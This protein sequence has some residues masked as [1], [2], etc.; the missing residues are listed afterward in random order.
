MKF[1]FYITFVYFFIHLLTINI[2]QTYSNDTLKSSVKGIFIDFEIKK[3]QDNRKLALQKSY[4]VG[5]IRYLDWI[6]L[7]SK[8]T[9]KKLTNNIEPSTLVTSYS[10]E[11]EKFSEERYSA[12]ITVNYD[13]KNR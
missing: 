6:T 9:I 3:N 5:L 8:E 2:Q 7:S 1:K 12:L 10:I 13:L 4:L 11:N